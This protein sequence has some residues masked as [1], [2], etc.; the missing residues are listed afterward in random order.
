[1]A[2]AGKGGSLQ[3][4][5][6][7]AGSQGASYRKKHYIYV[8]CY[9]IITH[10][11]HEFFFKTLLKYS[12]LQIAEHKNQAEIYSEIFAITNYRI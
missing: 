6:T 12:P 11:F 2:A 7:T 1:V 4:R 8:H 10:K 9:V 5:A 3:R